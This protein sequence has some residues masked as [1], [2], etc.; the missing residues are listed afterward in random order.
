MSF[1]VCTNADAGRISTSFSGVRYTALH[2]KIAV[3]ICFIDA[4]LY[5]DKFKCEGI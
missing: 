4:G 1:E 5:L 3:A 2:G